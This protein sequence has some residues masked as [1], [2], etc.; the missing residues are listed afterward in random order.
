VGHYDISGPKKLCIKVPVLNYFGSSPA[1][2][3]EMTKTICDYQGFDNCL[4]CQ[5]V[6]EYKDYYRSIRPISIPE[7][8]FMI[9]SSH[10]ELNNPQNT[11]A[12]IF[13]NRSKSIVGVTISSFQAAPVD[14]RRI[15]MS[16]KKHLALC[17]KC[18]CD[19][20]NSGNGYWTKNRLAL[21]FAKCRHCINT[22][23]H[24]N[25]PVTIHK[26]P[27]NLTQRLR[28]KEAVMNKYFPDTVDKII[29]QAK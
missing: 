3:K 19:L 12:H 2:I 14:L 29:R 6:L 25:L 16:P 9:Y 27:C 22:H 13:S 21:E 28:R 26:V 24:N 17:R 8:Y 20:M 18:Y 23:I 5:R 1:F 10:C 4:E 11:S 15:Q 7:N